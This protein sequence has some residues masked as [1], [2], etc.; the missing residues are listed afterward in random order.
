METDKRNILLEQ[1]QKLE[2]VIQT[3]S[4]NFDEEDIAD[5][6]NFLHIVKQNLEEWSE[7]KING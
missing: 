6:V 4:A 1:V 2:E 5:E 7:K 3:L